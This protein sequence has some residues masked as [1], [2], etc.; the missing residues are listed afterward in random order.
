MLSVV[1]AGLSG[2]VDVEILRRLRL[3]QRRFWRR[4][5]NRWNR[6]RRRTAANQKDERAKR[7][8]YNSFGHPALLVVPRPVRHSPATS[9]S[10]WNRVLVAVV[11]PDPARVGIGVGLGQDAARERNSGRDLNLRKRLRLRLEEVIEI[12]E[13][14]RLIRSAERFKPER[15]FGELKQRC[16]LDVGV[17]D[18]SA[19]CI[20]GNDQ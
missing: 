2:V 16:E 10:L 12:V 7:G 18:M 15:L 3:R 20:G 13:I 8:M 19:L 1:E 9:R 14:R 6:G 5:A 17:C 4:S 11:H